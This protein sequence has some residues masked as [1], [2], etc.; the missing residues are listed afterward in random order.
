MITSSLVRDWLSGHGILCRVRRPS[1]RAQ[2]TCCTSPGMS[3]VVSVLF[4]KGVEVAVSLT[5]VGW[6]KVFSMDD[7]SLCLR[8]LLFVSD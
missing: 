5:G 3:S 6:F 7:C 4:A 8:E 2:R 1:E